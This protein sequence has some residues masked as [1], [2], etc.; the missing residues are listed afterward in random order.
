MRLYPS[1]RRASQRLN[2]IHVPA[3]AAVQALTTLLIFSLCLFPTLT[4]AASPHIYDVPQAGPP[5]SQTQTVG[6]GW[7]PNATLDIYLDSTHV[8]L[9]DTDNNGTFGMA[10]KAPTIRQSGLAI[11]IPKDAVQGKHWITAVERITQLQAQVP[12]TVRFDWPQPRFDTQNSGFNPNESVLSAETVANLTVLWK[13]P[14]QTGQPTVANGAVYASSAFYQQENNLFALDA[15]TG[16][17]HWKSDPGWSGGGAT[18]VNGVLYVST[19][20]ATVALNASS[21][22]LLWRYALVGG[23]PPLVAN[24][25]VYVSCVVCAGDSVFALNA[26]TG[27][28]LWKYATDFYVDGDA[29][30]DGVVYVTSRNYV[31]AL[32]AGTG[33]PLWQVPNLLSWDPPAVAKGLVYLDSG[34][35]IYALNAGTGAFIW[36]YNTGNPISAPPA[37]ANGVVYVTSYETLFALDA[38]TG[39]MLWKTQFNYLVLLSPVVANG[40]VFVGS[41]IRAYALDASTGTVLWKYTTGNGVGTFAVVNGVVYVSSGDYLYAFGLPNQRMA[42]NYSPPE[43]PDPARLTLNW[44][45]RP[46]SAVTPPLKK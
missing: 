2:S 23:T 40:L 27:A 29:V 25:V 15:D 33:A 26:D 20:D 5:G 3:K 13:Y 9:V 7:D 4:T 31:Y 28:P 24:G 21:G 46:N 22:A 41:E 36:K 10:L 44:S 19:Q 37:V 38:G 17:L 30:A 8:G 6:N 32:D 14:I 18:V 35:D 45:L 42:E 34:A 12:F 16:A 11:Q 43:R 1:I 39:A